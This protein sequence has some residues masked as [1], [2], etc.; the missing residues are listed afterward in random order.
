MFT[1]GQFSKVTALPVKTLRFYHEKN[2][3]I[4]ARVEAGTGYRYYDDRN[5]QTARVITA[6]RTLEFSLD[7]IAE[8]LA[9]H[10]DDSDILHF[11]EQRKQS[12]RDRIEH[13]RDIVAT[14]DRI[15]HNE[16]EARRTMSQTQFEIEEKTLPPQ[17]VA[18][19]RMQCR[20]DEIGTGFSQI[21][22]K[23]G[24]H[25]SGKPLCLYYDNEYREED[26][27]LEP[28]MPLRKSVPVDGIS[29]REL[30]GGRCVALVH[31]GPYQQLGRSYE[32]VL[33][34]CADHGYE[35]QTPTREVYL[36]G[37][38]MIFRGNPKNYLTEIQFLIQEPK[39]AP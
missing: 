38:G 20:Y 30:P 17:F 12:L 18:G 32:R 19:I 25:I 7:E 14:I 23:L 29:V 3:L 36:K 1:I 10:D 28:C 34:H 9:Q 33:K 39:P 8:I 15:V 11:L 21:G 4:P 2:L 35:I 22:R 26:A 16:Q 5:I 24:R 13:D 31:R 37:P 6:L 27:D